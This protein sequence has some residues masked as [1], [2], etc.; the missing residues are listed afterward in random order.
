MYVFASSL[1]LI[2]LC[3]AVLLLIVSLCNHISRMK[4]SGTGLQSSHWKAHLNVL[5]KMVFSFVLFIVYFLT[6]A[7]SKFSELTTLGL[8][9]Y[10]TMPP[11]YSSVHS[12]F[13]IYSDTRL[14]MTFLQICKWVTKC[15]KKSQPET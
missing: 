10:I 2:L 13:L 5:K 8:Y 15:A 6:D 12:G 9:F 3:P 7:L 1:P 11:F 4:R 14:K